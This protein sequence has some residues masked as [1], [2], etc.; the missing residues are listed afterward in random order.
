MA[1]TM[2]GKIANDGNLR[3]LDG[4][5]RNQAVGY[6]NIYLGFIK[7]AIPLN[8]ASTLSG[9]DECEGITR[10]DVTSNFSSAAALDNGVP[11]ISNNSE[12][13]T[14]N[15]TIAE[16]LIGWF[17]TGAASG[18]SGKILAYG[19]VSSGSLNTNIGSP[20]TVAVNALVINND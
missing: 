13:T 17:I 8:D 20:V 2:N 9:I 3:M 4:L 11:E 19:N 10:T 14:A 12:I 16:S 1:V 6:A 5:F 7:G 18:T 15:A